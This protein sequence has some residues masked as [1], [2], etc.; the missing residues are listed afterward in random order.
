MS[1]VGHSGAWWFGKPLHQ[2]L[3]GGESQSNMLPTV[4]NGETLDSLRKHS[5]LIYNVLFVHKD[6]VMKAILFINLYFKEYHLLGYNT[7]YLTD[8]SEEHFASIFR[9]EK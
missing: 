4:L 9:V 3:H 8:V 7:V 2:L 5:P 6:H 1:L